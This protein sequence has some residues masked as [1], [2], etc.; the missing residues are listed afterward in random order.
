MRKR[1]A[2]GRVL[3]LKLQMADRAALDESASAA[4]AAVLGEKR[5][6]CCR[7]IDLASQRGDRG[8]VVT[9]VQSFLH[10]DARAFVAHVEK[11]PTVR[12]LLLAHRFRDE[13]LRDEPTA[14]QIAFRIDGWDRAAIANRRLSPRPYAVES[15]R[16]APLL[17]SSGGAAS[18]GR[19]GGA[20]SG[21]A[22]SGRPGIGVSAN[23]VSIGAMASRGAGAASVSPG[24]TPSSVQPA[25][26]ARSTRCRKSKQRP[27]GIHCNDLVAFSSY[28]VPRYKATITLQCSAGM[29]ILPGSHGRRHQRQ[30][31]SRRS[32]DR[33]GARSHHRRVIAPGRRQHLGGKR[34][35]TRRGQQDDDLSPLG[36]AGKTVRDAL[37]HIANEGIVVPDTGKLR[38][39][40]SKLIDMF[41]MVVASPHT[42]AL[43]RMHLS[44]TM[45]GDLAALALSIHRQ[46]DEQMKTVF[47]RAVARGELPPDTDVDLLYDT[48]V[49]TF[50]NLTFF[51]PERSSRARIEQ[52]VD[53]ILVGAK[54]ATRRVRRT[55]IQSRRRRSSKPPRPRSSQKPRKSR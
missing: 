49:G 30:A 29:S 55:A 45:H 14:A 5:R 21:G 1:H 7:T 19:S 38:S 12:P 40:V 46:K 18:G 43:I 37:L 41:H 6:P 54:T 44:G 36:D 47:V 20:A 52:A 13:A 17:A 50:F 15:R 28:T 31:G 4:G 10:G 2:A 26:K 42:H 24:S 48:L 8:D 32:F 39:D 27:H 23:P 33:Q 53:L 35:R 9:T 25:T 11:E 3:G 34:R 22:A 51:R 16:P